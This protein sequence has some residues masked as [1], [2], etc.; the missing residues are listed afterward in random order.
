MIQ[1]VLDG[2]GIRNGVFKDG[3]IYTLKPVVESCS[4]WR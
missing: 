2:H 3:K 1:N 4:E